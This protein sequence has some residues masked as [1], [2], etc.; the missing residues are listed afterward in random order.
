MVPATG[1]GSLTVRLTLPG[2]T[3]QNHVGKAVPISFQVRM[4]GRDPALLVEEKSTFVL[5]R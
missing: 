4:T 5:P 2:S 3:A 1:I